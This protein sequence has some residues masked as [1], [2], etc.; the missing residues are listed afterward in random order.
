MGAG[1]LGKPL[2]IELKR[3]GYELFVLSRAK[4]KLAYFQKYEIPVFEYDES[5]A[6]IIH[7]DVLI[8]CIPPIE[9]YGDF[10]GK[11]IDKYRPRYFVFCSSIG[12]YGQSHGVI[13]EHAETL[14]NNKIIAAED[15]L[16]LLD[17]PSTILRLGGL[18][19]PSRHPAMV[20]SGKSN[21]PG[22]LD[23]VNLIQ[24][25]DVIQM[26]ESVV[27]RQKPGVYNV[28]YPSH[29]TRKEYYET[30]CLSMGL[31]PCSFDAE[32]QG[33][34]V[35]GSLIESAFGAKYKYPI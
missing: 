15:A 33:K 6:D 25:Q 29:P 4:E 30:K 24:Q 20:F 13:T 23:P 9:S 5:P 3:K 18:I 11:Q 7:C 10:I 19:G 1:W 17:T 26:I 22:G 31:A 2:A 35:D 34:I 28:V 14:G 27:A 12:V 32:G 16:S 8:S 21:I